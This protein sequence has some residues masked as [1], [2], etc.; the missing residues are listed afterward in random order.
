M[1]E[2]V[3]TGT[4]LVGPD[5]ESAFVAAWA[6]FAAWASSMPGAPTLRLGRDVDHPTRFV[7]F[8]AWGSRDA[9]RT[10][11]GQPDFRARMAQVL[12]HV[13]DFHALELDV[14]AT[15]HEGTKTVT[16]TAVLTTQGRR[17]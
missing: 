1:A 8:A 11:K 7:S 3:T 16:A 6:D 14:L 17:S 10:W 13:E 9:V 4:W 5:Q 15:A 12:Q 2:L